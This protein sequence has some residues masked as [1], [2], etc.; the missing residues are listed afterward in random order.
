MGTVVN[1]TCLECEKRLGTPYELKL[2]DEELG[3]DGSVVFPLCKK[4]REWVSAS[5]EKIS[6][7]H[8]QVL[9]QRLIDRGIL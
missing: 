9:L 1:S 3:V 4:C 2:L 6:E 7:S 5:K 8:A